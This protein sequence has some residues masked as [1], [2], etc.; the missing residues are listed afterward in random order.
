MNPKMY[1]ASTREPWNK[2]KLVSQKAPLKL[3]DIWAIRVRLQLSN[4]IRNLALFNLAIDSKLGDLHWLRPDGIW[5]THHAENK[6]I[7][8]LPAHKEPESC[9]SGK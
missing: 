5:N 1:A 8:N 7:V 9:S 3:K 4:D 6:G 2:G